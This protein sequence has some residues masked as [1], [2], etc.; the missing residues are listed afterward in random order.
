MKIVFIAL[1]FAFTVFAQ[2]QQEEHKNFTVGQRLGTFALNIVPGL[3]SAVIMRDWVGTG[4]HWGLFGTGAVLMIRGVKEASECERNCFLVGI[5]WIIFGF[6]S[7]SF[8]FLF[9]I[10]RSATYDNPKYIQQLSEKPG[11]KNFTVG[12]RFGTFALNTVPG[13]GSIVV[14]NDWAGAIIQWLFIGSGIASIDS[15]GPILICTSIAFNIYRSST[16]NKPENMAFS[17]NDGFH[18]SVLPNK[19]GKVMPYLLFSKAF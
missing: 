11:Y 9:N 15:F 5:D 17:K 10:V 18:L 3:G 6:Y 4:I 16:Y 12:Q 19:H 8:D 1:C 13:L 2:E 7:W 14:M